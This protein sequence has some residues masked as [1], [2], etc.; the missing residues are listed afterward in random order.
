MNVLDEENVKQLDTQEG[1]QLSPRR[2][3]PCDP[4][5][6]APG[7]HDDL[8]ALPRYQRGQLFDERRVARPVEEEII[9]PACERPTNAPRVLLRPRGESQAT[10]RRAVESCETAVGGGA[11]KLHRTDVVADSANVSKVRQMPATGAALGPE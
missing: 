10:C 4:P 9:D 5:A 7:S 1:G 2:P 8:R 11:F 6:A 3:Q